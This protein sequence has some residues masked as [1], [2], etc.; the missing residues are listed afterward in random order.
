[1]NGK[2]TRRAPSNRTTQFAGIQGARMKPTQN[3]YPVMWECILGTVYAVNPEGEIRYF[4]YDKE[5]A[6]EYIG[7]GDHDDVRIWRKED[8]SRY[9]YT[10]P[11]SS[12][13]K[14]GKFAVW[15]RR[16]S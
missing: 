14:K 2:A 8:N 11:V 1:M 10:G 3:H 7:F 5:A 6:R 9:P 15:V 16:D 12:H 4:D 13:L